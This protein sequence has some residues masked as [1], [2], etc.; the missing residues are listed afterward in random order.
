MKVL[1]DTVSYSKHE[2]LRQAHS[3][4]VCFQVRRRVL[5][6]KTRFLATALGICVKY[7]LFKHEDV[8]LDSQ[9]P[10]GSQVWMYTYS[11]S[12]GVIGMPGRNEDILMKHLCPL[13]RLSELLKRG[14]PRTFPLVPGI[15]C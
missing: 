9:C 3:A 7:L 12:A 15:S 10:Y 13:L 6:F 14:T 1:R 8:T 4:N 11:P 2:L 5:V